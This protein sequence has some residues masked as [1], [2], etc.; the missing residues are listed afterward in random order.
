MMK[1]VVS[2]SV[3]VEPTHHVEYKPLL[4]K[5]LAH[6]K[7]RVSQ[8]IIF[9]RTQFPPAT[10]NPSIDVDWVSAVDNATPFHS[11]VPVDATV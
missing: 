5:A 7:H 3:G 9:Q 4:D 11:C 10:L 2:A 1:V 8:C 6:S